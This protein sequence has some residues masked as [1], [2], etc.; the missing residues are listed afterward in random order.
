MFFK[1]ILL[2][3]GAICIYAQRSHELC[4][5]YGCFESGD[6]HISMILDGDDVFYADFKKGL[7]IWDSKIPTDIHV[8]SAYEFS[9]YYRSICKGVLQRSK[10]DKSITTNTTE[11]PEISIFPRDEVAEDEENTLICFINNFFPP[12]INVKWTKNDEELVQEDAFNKCLPNPDGTFYVF[13][14]LTFVPKTGDI[15]SCTVEHEALED[16]RT[17]FWVVD[18][19]EISISSPAVFCGLGLT[20]GLLGVAAGTFFFA[21]GSQYQGTVERSS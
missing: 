11:A 18:T 21:K 19:D 2:L 5:S 3:S 12:S 13:S 16:P 8:A 10:P 17:K 20:L 9:L 14:H 15:Y 4:L 6:T 7:L 1:I